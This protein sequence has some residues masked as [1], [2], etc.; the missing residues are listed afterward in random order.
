MA[1]KN[2]VEH[3][4]SE[5]FV[6][7][8]VFGVL[9]RNRPKNA[10]TLLDLEMSPSDRSKVIESIKVADYC[11]GPMDDQLYG[12]AS[13]WVFGKTYKKHELYIKISMGTTSSSVI[14]ISFHIAEHSMTYPFK[15][16]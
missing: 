1:T 8:K 2:E 4:L 10:Q 16:K 11:E 14:C 6:K 13:M 15:D 3:F 5:F 9:Y 7:Y 12:I